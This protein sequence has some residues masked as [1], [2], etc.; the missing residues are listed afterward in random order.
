REGRWVRTAVG[1]E[2]AV[3][4]REHERL[5]SGDESPSPASPPATSAPPAP[6]IDHLAAR[7]LQMQV[8][9][10]KPR[11]VR[12][13]RVHVR[14]IL[15]RLRGRR[16]DPLSSGGL[17]AFVES[18]RRDGV[19]DISIC[20]DLRVLKSLLRWSVAEGMLAAMPVRVRMLRC[21]Q[22]KTIEVFTTGE[23]ESVL[24]A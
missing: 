13:A 16:A 18:R 2:L 17:D 4:V 22:R 7:W 1:R 23:M 5:R 12:A 10:S 20:N 15:E 11:T 14:R 3:A 19:K 24:A 6:T 9:R 21:V 8:V